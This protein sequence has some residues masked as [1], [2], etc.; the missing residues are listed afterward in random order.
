MAITAATGGKNSNSIYGG[1]VDRS[2]WLFWDTLYFANNLAVPQTISAFSIAIQQ[3]NTL[4]AVGGPTNGVPK[5]KLQTNMVRPNQ[6]PPPRCLLLLRIGIAFS[7]NFLK[8]DIDLIMNSAYMEFKIDEKIF[9]EGWLTDF[10]QGG[11]LVGATENSGESCWTNG[12]PSLV[13]QRN[14]GDWAKYIA[15]EQ[16]FSMQLIFGGGG[17]T[18][19]VIGT[20][21]A[22]NNNYGGGSGPAGVGSATSPSASMRITLDG[23]TDRSVQ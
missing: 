3:S 4:G 10:P 1:V 20:G 12:I 8:P 18:I 13:Y 11:G 23:L 15:P 19:P 6:F 5:T 22:T 17:I 14:F 16:Q 21:T 9:H 2:P 7:N